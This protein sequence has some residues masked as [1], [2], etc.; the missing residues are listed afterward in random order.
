M[1]LY[2]SSG[3]CSLAAHIILE[4]A[5]AKFDVQR[6]DLREGE[7]HKPEYL[8]VNP[9]GQVPALQ[10]DGGVVLTENPAIIS[11]VA[12]THPGVGL[13]EAPGTVARAKAQEWLA[14]CAATV[15]RD[16]RPLFSARRMKID[17][18]PSARATAQAHLDTIDRHLAGKRFVLGDRFGAA[19][20]YTLVFALWAGYFGLTLGEHYQA[21]ARGLLDRAGVRRAVETQG[22][23]LDHLAPRSR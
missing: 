17:A 22:V 3:S 12:D 18:E 19:D 21:S 5:N 7:Q 16:F 14:W 9:K 10:L 20:A 8:K 1:K 6:I 4:E 13:L 11:Y 15:H 23:K 2:Y